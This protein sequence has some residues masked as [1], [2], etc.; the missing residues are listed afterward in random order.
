MATETL[1]GKIPHKEPRRSS[2]RNF[3]RLTVAAAGTATGLAILGIGG[4]ALFGSD[5]DRKVTKAPQGSGIPDSQPANNT[6]ASRIAAEREKVRKEAILN[7]TLQGLDGTETRVRD[8]AVQKPLVLIFWSILDGDVSKSLLTKMNNEVYPNFAD[9]NVQF[10]GVEIWDT[11]SD[12]NKQMPGYRK[13]IV[14]P[15]FPIVV[16][17]DSSKTSS[18]VFRYTGPIIL[19]DKGGNNV[20]ELGPSQFDQ[21]NPAIAKLASGN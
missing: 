3:L 14:D 4:K 21:V 12:L 16:A 11:L 9:A 15:K 13:S 8:L 2:R 1:D 19:I 10:L 5:D 18:D 7:I 20:T 17:K 6:D